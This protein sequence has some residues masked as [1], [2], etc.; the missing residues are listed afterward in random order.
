MDNSIW[1]KECNILSFP[2]LENDSKT[3]V[4]IIGGGLAGI[5][6]AY[7]LHKQGI[8]Y[9]LIEAGEVCR[10]ITCCT[11]AKITS[12]HGLIYQKLIHEFGIPFARK[13]WEANQWAIDQFRFLAQSVDCDFIERDSI[14]YSAVGSNKIQDE[15]AAL[16]QL[17][18][19]AEYTENFAL[20]FPA[21]G[22][23]FKDQAQ[24]HPLKFV[25]AIS[26]GLNLYEHTA[27]RRIDGNTVHTDKG[28][29]TANKIIVA[30]HFPI[31]NKHGGYFIKMYQERSYIMA[32]KGAPVYR[33]MYRDADPQ[34][35][36][37]R[38]HGDY[39][40]IGSGS[41]RTGKKSSGWQEI[42]LLRQKYY[43]SAQVVSQW[44]TQDCITLDGVPYIGQYSRNTP[45][46]YVATG[47]N[48]WGMTSSMLA[49]G[50][51]SDLIQGKQNE[52]APVFAPS[53]S[54]LRPQLLCNAMESTMNFFTPTAPRCPH[55][56]CA[57][58]WNAQEHSWDCP[59][60]GSRFTEDGYLLD[61]PATKNL[62]DNQSV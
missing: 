1:L 44:A 46:L 38:N 16:D 7:E 21:V 36:S 4:L 54:I 11:T 32:L 59:C 24:F 9:A 18:I 39:L 61:N 31:L 15:M 17:Q 41:H 8:D 34:G 29:I 22:I 51:L 28:K 47:F 30:T 43:P 40:I 20:P 60:H 37:F 56:G 58:K 12:Q 35:F 48:K 6:C 14:L 45:N 26:R 53:R 19:P 10:G 3:D 23:R 5:L 42:E 27:A 55:M 62:K 57:L 25:A 2:R 33:G 50:I 13:Y 52:Y 49:A